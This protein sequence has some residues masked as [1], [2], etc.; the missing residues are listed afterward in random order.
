MAETTEIITTSEII[1]FALNNRTAF[2]E[3]LI[4]DFILPAQRHYLRPFLGDDFYTEILDEV[5]ASTL[6]ADNSTLLNDYLKPM[7]SYYVIY[8]AW[9]DITVNVTSAGVMISK[10]ETSFNAGGGE[11]ALARDAK[12]A[13]AERWQKDVKKYIKDQQDADSSKFPLF[14]D[15]KDDSDFKGIIFY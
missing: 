14:D 12:R 2:D 10:S 9:H 8:D 13:M 7:V 15:S 6:T 5:E 11:G 3:D 1:S 4:S